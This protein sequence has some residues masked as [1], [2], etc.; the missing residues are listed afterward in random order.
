MLDNVKAQGYQVVTN[1]SELAA[2]TTADQDSPVLGLFSSGNMPRQFQ[3]TIPTEDGAQRDATRCELNPERTDSLP[4]LAQMTTK[5]I[6][7]LDR[8]AQGDDTGFFL[9][10]EGAS[11]DKADHSADACGQI[12]EL[13]DLDQAI[14]AVRA[15]VASSGEPTLIVATADHAHTSQITSDGQPTAGRTTRL[16]TADGDPMVISYATAA[17]NSHD[18]ALGGQN[19]TGAQLRIA[20]EGPGAENVVGQLDQTDLHYLIAGSLGLDTSATLSAGSFALADK[21]ELPEQPSAQ[22]STPEATTSPSA[23]QAAGP[24]KGDGSVQAGKASKPAKGSL[25]RT[26]AAVLAPALIATAAVGG[27]LALRR[28]RSC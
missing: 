5:A 24:G 25:A 6:E 20:A 17:S 16:L 9:Q 2:L 10:V 15:W 13:D 11:I 27:G 4:D 21:P 26:G 12:G 1:T 18:D 3:A 14:Q 22:P 23:G 8:S 7:L 28:R 19:H